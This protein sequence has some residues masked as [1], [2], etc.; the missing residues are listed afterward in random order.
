MTSRV[1][2]VVAAQTGF[3]LFAGAIT[4]KRIGSLI[5]L[6]IISIF[7]CCLKD[8][9]MILD[10]FVGNKRELEFFSSRIQIIFSS[11][12]VISQYQ[13]KAILIYIFTRPHA[14]YQTLKFKVR[15]CKT[16]VLFGRIF[17]ELNT[18]KRILSFTLERF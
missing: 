8:I 7:L 5:N 13:S 16:Y 17:E 4:S 11:S 9:L 6:S 3:L 18:E 12:L 10:S 15:R 14:N 1:S 2:G